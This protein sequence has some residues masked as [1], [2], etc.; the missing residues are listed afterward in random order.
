M[1]TGDIA[2]VSG[3]NV[4]I[5]GAAMGIGYGIAKR[6]AAAGANCLLVDLNADVLSEATSKLAL[7]PGQAKVLHVDITDPGAAD[8]VVSGCVAMYGSVDVLVN[9]AGIFPSAPTLEMTPEFFRHVI[10]VNLNAAVF[11]SKAVGRQMAKQG[12]GGK[13][14]NVASID[15]V[16]PSMEG[17]A[18]YD[19]SKGAVLMFSKNFALE[20]AKHGVQVNVV[21]PGAIATEGA[22]RPISSLTAEQQQAVLAEFIAKVPV[23][24]IGT[25]DDVAKAVQFLA[26]AGSD[27]MTGALV[28]VDGGR[29]L[30]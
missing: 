26:G 25:P 22:S 12:D 18:A 6:F 11:L 5:T 7:E 20:M 30:S 2:R 17:L 29:L 16:H 4:I 9:N 10:D 28:V 8:E 3:K 1:D 15:A 19:A 23:G 24:R 21:A 27:Y 13:I 14:V